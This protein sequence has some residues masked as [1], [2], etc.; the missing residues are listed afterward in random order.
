MLGDRNSTPESG[1]GQAVAEGLSPRMKRLFTQGQAWS[2]RRIES[3]FGTGDRP[4]REFTNA[5]EYAYYKY[6]KGIGWNDVGMTQLER[7][8]MY[9]AHNIPLSDQDRAIAAHCRKQDRALDEVMTATGHPPE[10]WSS[11][12]HDSSVS[13]NGKV[14]Q[15]AESVTEAAVAV[16]QQ[17][18]E[19][20][21]SKTSG[22]LEKAILRRRP[23][24][25]GETQ[26]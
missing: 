11:L 20:V 25:P 22:L 19:V 14:W 5:G 15:A 21:K 16:S 8:R 26:T 13:A 17:V 10:S 4:K 2:R 6:G 7:I 12:I 3:M 18:V 24:P 1:L 23:P 9:I